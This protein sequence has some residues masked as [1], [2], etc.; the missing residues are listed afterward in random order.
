MYGDQY[1][2]FDLAAVDNHLVDLPNAALTNKK[3]P[4]SDDVN[5]LFVTPATENELFSDGVVQLHIATTLEDT[6]PQGVGGFT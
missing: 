2:N 5:T 4:D 3:Y 1:V 6:T